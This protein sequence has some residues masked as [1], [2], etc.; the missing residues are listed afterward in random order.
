MN[1]RLTRTTSV[2]SAVHATATGVRL[3]S[4]V[5]TGLSAV[6]SQQKQ[7]QLPDGKDQKE[8]VHCGTEKSKL[9]TDGCD[10]NVTGSTGV[11]GQTGP[12][13]IGNEGTSNPKTDGRTEIVALMTKLGLGTSVGT[14][15][16]ST[17]LNITRKFWRFGSDNSQIYPWSRVVFTAGT[18]NT[19][20][21]QTPYMGQREAWLGCAH[22]FNTANPYSTDIAL[23]GVGFSTQWAS[24]STAALTGATSNDMSLLLT[25]IPTAAGYNTQPGVKQPNNSNPYFRIGPAIYIHEIRGKAIIRRQIN[26][27]GTVPAGAKSLPTKFPTVLSYIQHEPI[28]L[29]QTQTNIGTIFAV[30]AGVEYPQTEDSTLRSDFVSYTDND[31]KNNSVAPLMFSGATSANPTGWDFNFAAA[32]ANTGQGALGGSFPYHPLTYL[33]RTP[34]IQ[35]KIYSMHHKMHNSDNS[36]KTVLG[37]SGANYTQ[38]Q[39]TDVGSTGFGDTC[40]PS[41]HSFEVP[42]EHKFEGHGLKVVYDQQDLTGRLAAINCLRWKYIQDITGYMYGYTDNTQGT[43]TTN[44]GLGANSALPV[45]FAYKEQMSY[46]I[47]VE[48]SDVPTQL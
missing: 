38:Y 30:T 10:Q 13:N 3:P 1:G 16:P 40:N 42:I 35:T 20:L 25:A 8:C 36:E 19:F 5:Q 27:T 12:K 15:V 17:S 2:H 47:W 33:H 29:Q 31:N 26:N 23:G 32:T 34:E 18:P 6:L 28:A 22:V 21:P 39:G 48:F 41:F 9:G 46:E 7:T 44:S 11:S 4:S 14:S 43:Q 24:G 45:S 37:A